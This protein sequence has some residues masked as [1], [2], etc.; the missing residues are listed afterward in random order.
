MSDPVSVPPELIAL[1]DAF[2]RIL[3]K[4]KEGT[5]PVAP[6]KDHE[7]FEIVGSDVLSNQLRRLEVGVEHLGRAI[8]DLGDAVDVGECDSAT[9]YGKLGRVEAHVEILR[10][11]CVEVGAWRVSG[12]DLVARALMTAIYRHTLNEIQAW[13]EDMVA[14]LAD[15]ISKLEKQE[16]SLTEQAE[17][18]QSAAGPV[19]PAVTISSVLE[20]TA[21]PELSALTEWMERQAKRQLREQRGC[22]AG[23]WIFVVGVLFGGW[24]GGWGDDERDTDD[25]P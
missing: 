24:L 12:E 9:V 19:P 25:A 20:F 6:D 2:D 16:I 21:A 3:Q 7:P 8:N 13:L 15:V 5:K 17:T 10:E 22:R 4:L 14:A 11:E 23:I 1:H 18:S